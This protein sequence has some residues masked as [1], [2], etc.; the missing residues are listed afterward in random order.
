MD[1]VKKAQNRVTMSKAWTLLCMGVLSACIWGYASPAYSQSVGVN[2]DDI[3]S[4]PDEDSVLGRPRPEYSAQGVPLG[5]F[6]LYPAITLG[7]FYDDNV[8]RAA[9]D[10]EGDTFFEFAP[11]LSLRSQWTRHSLGMRASATRYQ[12]SKFSSENKTDWTIV[13]NGRV[14][15]AT[16]MAFSAALQHLST[17]ER[18]DSPDQIN[19]AEPTPYEQTGAHLVFSYNPYRLGLQLAADFDRTTFGNT[20]VLAEA[21]GGEQDNH[22]R[23]RDDYTIV[24]T[25]LYEFSPGYAAFLRPTYEKRIYDL[26]T[27]RAQGRN[28]EGYR[29]DTGVNLLLSR[30]IR[31]EVYA[32]YI[33]EDLEG[34]S[35]EDLSGL[36][37]G[38]SLQWFPSEVITVHLDASRIPAATTLVG[39]SL[40]DDR[41][42]EIG[43]D[44]EFRRNVIVQADFQYIDAQF[45]GITR[46]DRNFSTQVGVRYLLNPY[47]SANARFTHNNRD[48]TEGGRTFSDN[49]VAISVNAHL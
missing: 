13:G 27:A 38:A 32:G 7:T 3:D 25:A 15:I 14:D 34:P 46:H 9:S 12:F 36:D 30:L 47:L 2:P 39:A 41:T 17:S 20:K 5:G 19:A 37:Y 24:G 10:K 4:L 43:V 6:R 21:G 33:R 44:Y 26:Q 49:V 23:D 11:Q 16:G 8:F 48:S 18:R 35:F 42:V 40:R 1:A 45:E 31:G 28:T 29:I 22:D